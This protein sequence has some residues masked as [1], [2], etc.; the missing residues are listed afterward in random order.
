MAYFKAQAYDHGDSDFTQ[1]I[2]EIDQR[3]D[4]KNLLKE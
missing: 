2:E 3:E 4:L 1:M